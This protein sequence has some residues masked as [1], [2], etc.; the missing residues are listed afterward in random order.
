MGYAGAGLGD[1]TRIAAGEPGMWTEICLENQREIRRALEALID[2]LGQFQ[3]ALENHDE[4]QLKA[5]LNRAKHY[6]DEL[7]FRG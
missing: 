1:S 5:L 7:K 3:A 6:R 2:E 4:G